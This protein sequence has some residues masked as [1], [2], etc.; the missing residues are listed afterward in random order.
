MIK[1]PIFIIVH[2]QY[3]ILKKSV[4]SYETQIDYPIEIVF[5][6]VASKY[7]E[8]LNY[9]KE[10]ENEGYL[11]YHSSINRHVSVKRSIENYLSKHPECEYIIITD[12]DIQLYNINKDIIQFYIHLLNTTN[13]VAVGPMLKI[14]DIPNYYPSKNFI[15]S[16]HGRGHWNQ[17]KKSI[18][19]NGNKYE[20]INT[21]IDTTFQLLRANK[22]PK[23]FPTT[24]SIRTLNPYAARHLDWYIN[25]NNIMPCQLFYFFNTTGLS[26][27]NNRESKSNMFTRKFKKPY[28]YIYINKKCA[29]SKRGYNFGDHVTSYIFYRIYNQFAHIDINGGKE[30]KDVVFGAGSI[31]NKAKNNSIIWGTGFMF[32]TDK[33]IK[34]KKILS[35]R[36][37]LT[38]KRL[39]DIG[40]EC[41]ECYGDIGLI[42][43]YFYYPSVNKKH[44]IGIIPHYIDIP[45]FNNIHTEDNEDIKIIDVSKSVSEVI[46]DILSC[47]M[48]ISSSLH[49]I[50]VSHAYNIRCLW[51]KMSDLIAGGTFKFRDYYGSLN[52]ENYE[53]ME[54]YIYD[55]Q[56]SIDELN[57]LI[58]EYPNPEFPI[59]T[60]HILQK[61]PFINIGTEFNI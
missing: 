40:L 4:E 12:P 23:K 38:R 25:P 11:V 32:P 6:N 16:M 19:F 21:H 29:K 45:T 30:K 9:L 3:D 26:H 36:G 20:Y 35:V 55:K 48:T 1:I 2:D 27:W 28:N 33:A 15:V 31:L 52:M 37:P 46:C 49:G 17:P 57:K 18:E 42:L 10:K 51:I 53:K 47:E 56:L 60:K 41:P 39:L 7:F 13:K 44:K 8:T 5:H 14:D 50:I 22:I 59:N 61:C 58:N 24:N 43:P 34:P 54:P